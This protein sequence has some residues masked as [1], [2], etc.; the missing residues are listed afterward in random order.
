MI[1]PGGLAQCGHQT[2]RK[3]AP[4]GQVEIHMCR[5]HTLTH[6]EF[7][8]KLSSPTSITSRTL[9]RKTEDEAPY[10]CVVNWV[11]T[12]S[13]LLM[14]LRLVVSRT[15]SIHCSEREW[16]TLSLSLWPC[17]ILHYANDAP[18]RLVCGSSS[19]RSALRRESFSNLHL[20]Y[21]LEMFFA[22]GTCVALL[23]LR[24]CCFC[25]RIYGRGGNDVAPNNDEIMFQNPSA[26]RISAPLSSRSGEAA[27]RKTLRL[28]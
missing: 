26:M 27:A 8:F 21:R 17:V 9:A 15:V 1:P 14:A 24:C 5:S 2:R 20:I 3:G 22:H 19:Y 23:L 25:S 11:S 12:R 16:G 6:S 10:R 28:V 4:Q 18:Q 7:R 13:D